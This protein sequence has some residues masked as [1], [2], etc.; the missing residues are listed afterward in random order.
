MNASRTLNPMSHRVLT[1][2]WVSL[3]LT[4]TL[5]NY[6]IMVASVRTRPT[7]VFSSSGSGWMKYLGSGVLGQKCH[8]P[9]VEDPLPKKATTD[10]LANKGFA[11]CGHLRPEGAH[12]H[13]KVNE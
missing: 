2:D 3:V 11:V 5:L 12:T 4:G 8:N 9:L 10:R 13:S 6:D 7:C 1:D